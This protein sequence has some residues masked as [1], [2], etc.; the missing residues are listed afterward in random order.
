MKICNPIENMTCLQEDIKRLIFM[1]YKNYIMCLL[2]LCLCVFWKDET[3]DSGENRYNYLERRL[4]LTAHLKKYLSE[5]G[6]LC[7]LLQLAQNH[8]GDTIILH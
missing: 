4:M 7:S 2:F 3:D 5:A 6:F 8:Y 1:C